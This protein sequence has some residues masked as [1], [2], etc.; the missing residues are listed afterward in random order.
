MSFSFRKL[1]ICAATSVL[2][3]P[4]K[5]V[6]AQSSGDYRSFSSG[7][8]NAASTWERFD[9]SNWI[10][11]PPQG[12]PT[13]TMGTITI[14][15]GHTV[16]ITANISIDQ[17]TINS[18]G[19]V[20]LNPGVTLTV[21][22]GPG[23]APDLSVSGI[24]KNAGTITR[25][26]T[27]A[28]N[29]GGKYQHNFTTT[30]G[31]IPS[32]TWNSGS[33]C[34]IIGYSTLGSLGNIGFGQS[35][36]NFTWNC[37]AQ[38][39]VLSMSGGLTT[40]RGN[41]SIISTGTGVLQ[42]ANSLSANRTLAVS[43]DYLQSGGTL[44]LLNANSTYYS[45]LNVAGNFS[46]SGGILQKGAG[47]GRIF[48]TGT[49]ERTYTK[50]GGSISGAI[51]ITINS[52]AI[53]NFGTSVLDGS[54][55]FTLASGATIITSHPNGL[56]NNGSIQTTG[57][58]SFNSGANYQFRGASTGTFTTTT[59]NTVKNI[60]INSSGTSLAQNF[61]VNGTVALT[62]GN[63]SLG[64]YNLT[65]AAA[66]A[67]VGYRSS[68]YIKT[69]GT[70]QLKRTVSNIAT[71]FPVGKSSYNPITLTNSGTSDVYGIRVA[72]GAIPANIAYADQTVNRRWVITENTANGSNL[73]V[74]A[75]YNSGEEGNGFDLGTYN[76]IGFYN[77]TFWQQ[78]SAAK[79]GVDPYTFSSSTTFSAMGDLSTGTK[80]FGIGRNNGFI[81]PS[82]LVI[83]SISPSVPIA[84]TSFSVTVQ[85]QDANN[86]PAIVGTKTAFD[87]SSSGPAGPLSGIIS[88]TISTGANSATVSGARFSSFGT[89]A[90]TAT[91]TS[92]ISLSP[93]T[94][95]V[96]DVLAAEPQVQASDI[97][98]SDVDGGGMTINWNSAPDTYSIVL[99]KSGGTVNSNPVDGT[100]YIANSAFRSG[101]QLG[102]GNFVVF[103]GSG[104]SV[105][106]TGLSAGTTYYVAIYS[107]NGTTNFTNYLTTNPA[108]E[109]QRSLAR[110]DFRSKLSG[111]WGN[112]SNWETW[113]GS[114]WSAPNSFPTNANGVITIREGHTISVA[115]NVTADQLT[116]EKGGTLFIN[117][118]K[119][120]TIANLTSA[121]I[122]AE[123]N[124]TVNIAGT[125]TGSGSTIWINGGFVKNSGT[126]DIPSYIFDN[127]ASYE[128]ARNGGK[129]PN[130]TWQ[131]GTT[132]LV[133]GITNSTTLEGITGEFFHNFIWNCPSQTS[134]LN[135]RASTMGVSG[136]FKI[137]S[138]GSG[139]LLLNSTTSTLTISGDYI[140]NAGT[141]AVVSGDAGTLNIEGNFSQNGG[142]LTT[143]SGAI[144]RV[145]FTKPGS[146][147]FTSSNNTIGSLVEFTVNKGSTLS[148]GTSVI[149]GRSFTLSSGA[150]LQT[151][152]PEGISS[153]GSIGA[154][155]TV[156]RSFHSG[157]DYTF[158]GTSEQVTGNG[159]P[160][161]IRNL[162]I[163]NTSGVTLSSNCS[164]N[165]TL[166]LNS[167]LFN[168][169]TTTL[170]VISDISK[171]GGSL[172]SAATGTVIYNKAGNGQ[173]VISGRYGNLSFSNY[174]K[175]FE[176]AANSGNEPPDPANILIAGTLTTGT[177]NGHN[178]AES[179]ISFNGNSAQEIPA[180]LQYYSLYLSGSGTK[181][182]KAASLSDF[183]IR[184]NLDV[185]ASADFNNISSIFVAKNISGSKAL[186]TG[187]I[188]V[189]IGGDWKNTATGTNVTGL[190]TYNGESSTVQEVGALNYKD[191]T[192]TASRG[193]SFP[194]TATAVRGPVSVSRT[195][196][197]GPNCELASN[198]N[199]T[200]LASENSNANVAPLVENALI[201]GD[202]NVQSFIKGGASSLRGT[203][204]MSSPIS[205]TNI[206][207]QLKSF[208]LVTGPS[209]VAGGFDAGGKAQ[210]NAVTIT[211][212]NEAAGLSQSAF[213]PIETLDDAANP[214]GVGFMVFFR[215][216]RSN[217]SSKLN[218]P[219]AVPEN[220]TVVYNGPLNQGDI[221]IP[222]P[223]SNNPGDPYNGYLL[224]GNPYASTIDF[225]ELL[226]ASD[227]INPI[228]T[229]VKAGQP[230]AT[231]HADLNLSANSGS[232][233]IQP[234]QAF[235]IS[236]IEEGGVLRFNENIKKIGDDIVPGRLLSSPVNS[237]IGDSIKLLSRPKTQKLF[238]SS[239]E[240]KILRMS[241]GDSRSSEEAI[242][243][244]RED[245]SKE[246]DKNDAPYFAGTTV[247]LSTLSS[248][249]VAL[250]INTVPWENMKEIPLN[251]NAS[252]SG[253]MTLHF[254][255]VPH[256]LLY[257]ISL[258]D[259]LNGANVPVTANG[260]YNFQI[261]LSNSSTFGSGRLAL[262]VSP[263]KILAVQLKSFTVK[264]IPTGA[265]IKWNT[266]QEKN[267][268][269][270]QIERSIDGKTFTV[271][272]SV[273]AAGNSSVT[274]TYSY[275]DSNPAEGVNYYRLKEISTSRG[276]SYSNTID[277]NWQIS[278]TV[279]L[280]VYPNPTEKTLSVQFQ[281][282][283]KQLKFSVFDLQG[284]ELRIAEG[285]QVNVED[286]PSGTYLIRVSE[287][288]NGNVLGTEKIIKK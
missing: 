270:F 114:Q 247:N 75:Q 14:Q 76:F 89:A 262:V 3:L 211:N 164:V 204:A 24:F 26:G 260:D 44:T 123:I 107:Y 212:Y 136:D 219:F 131:E 92:G 261:D 196:T 20:V 152:H 109:H 225:H 189:M 268:H 267:S 102:S 71:V 45:Y 93:G 227:G 96:F 210:P 214:P 4:I 73:S 49:A 63:L 276:P 86:Q 238:S 273:P 253:S 244:F 105:T 213:I 226:E 67:I 279:E 157:A 119:T 235:Y 124:G 158:N 104:S 250:S 264:K 145:F 117:S 281:G 37:P 252:Y 40:V 236:A 64:N 284:R 150:E 88:G 141:F 1:L 2:L 84:G 207:E 230:A 129:V 286:L 251:V 19:Q 70:G 72:D 285:N 69:E 224:A 15:A 256:S 101:S 200:L 90:I 186:N 148:L 178:T 242:I 258:K 99:M 7:N 172:A 62:S 280:S 208:I 194:L 12:T 195:L 55:P 288:A 51:P 61:I 176:S 222:V 199:I 38:S 160:S 79:A 237:P 142:S 246:A 179:I 13:S 83:T 188:P 126:C 233:Y 39:T 87:I 205:S 27:I 111:E 77:G 215:G 159:L 185:N 74:V 42:L 229:I 11:S 78:N 59:A 30:A 57:T 272:G 128:H 248:D 181:T 146:Q 9:G 53:V 127:K 166:L 218:A 174:N 167:G 139:S 206:Y 48:F 168:I 28:F 60:T 58:K 16:T 47:N 41:L 134:A 46:I 255:E 163:D 22:N 132:C 257:E 241:I 240:A 161:S 271:I 162:T 116:V 50:S 263:A 23:S 175:V 169:G 155:Q 98:F 239:T 234:G 221:E 5:N 135:M 112:T 193:E 277:L 143:T 151:A 118:G 154:V 97:N 274:Q 8:W 103:N 36:Y 110:G 68:A 278:S 191:L 202:V 25:T 138:T 18:G 121:S 147:T 165:G 33:T 81:A 177:A 269:S 171:T 35:F 137:V 80:Y 254:T 287:S 100:S 153:S 282:Y 245:F 231:Y 133:T 216:D 203:R 182:I 31:S 66:G 266:T 52:G 249:S 190:Y 198:G 65:I 220:V 108:T 125:L 106:V 56:G 130:A 223:N 144:A 275:V 54:S 140:Q 17:V 192:I 187:S 173:T 201:T 228:V 183:R 156:A 6:F 91:R 265:E 283:E 232:R 149:T 32:S 29:S 82:K 209:G 184:G 95:S 34:E 197:V 85:A 10:A 120:L 259:N 217:A 122:E 94:S 180:S 113:T 243:A 115:T 43:G 21:A 170:T